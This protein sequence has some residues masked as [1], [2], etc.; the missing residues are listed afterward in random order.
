MDGGGF[1]I[2]TKPGHEDGCIVK[3]GSNVGFRE[4][5]LQPSLALSGRRAGRRS[6]QRRRGNYGRQQR[7]NDD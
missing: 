2:L 3:L 5:G 7:A 4:T 1:A 6:K